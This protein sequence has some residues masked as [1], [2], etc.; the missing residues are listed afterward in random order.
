VV[1]LS[2]LPIALV[3]NVVRITVTGIL[4]ELV[5]SDFANKVFH[6]LAGWLMMP[7]A[8]GML[9]LELT[10]IHHLLIEAPQ[11]IRR[12]V[13]PPPVRPRPLAPRRPRPGLAA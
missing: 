7:L 1:A 6:D 3:S 13:R 4:H 8:L 2:A 5:S 12:G 9:W 11:S 10:L